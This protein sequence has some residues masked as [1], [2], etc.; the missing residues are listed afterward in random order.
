MKALSVS[1]ILLVPGFIA[2]SSEPL[3]VVDAGLNADA[4]VV[5]DAGPQQTPEERGAY[6][7]TAVLECD[8]CHTPEL[9][10]GEP[11]MSRHLAGRPEFVDLDRM[12]PNVGA[13]PAP[14]LTPHATG[15]QTWSDIQI[16][17]SLK[18]GYDKDEV[19][20][21]S[22]MPYWVYFNMS[23]RDLDA[24]V[25]YLRSIP[26]VDQAIPDR[27]PLPT[28]LNAPVAY[29]RAD[30]M[31]YSSLQFGDANFSQAQYGRYLVSFANCLNCH[32]PTAP[33]GA[34]VPINV[35][36]LLTGGKKYPASRFGLMSPPYPA[37][38]TA[39]NLTPS[40]NGLQG[41]TAEQVAAAL[42][43]GVDADGAGLC[44]P[45]T[46]GGMS[47]YARMTDEDAL[48]I[49]Y[50]LTTIPAVET[51]TATECTAQ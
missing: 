47:V 10:S 14:N 43:T 37:Q 24:I 35:T 28:P 50:Y 38:I 23:D 45:M 25:A 12:D 11:D 19:P 2:C 33:P 15:L 34:T 17:R 1:L 26:A 16:K 4:A 18:D 46:S 8:G 41:W 31:P 30:L 48:A 21:H 51:A 42:K 6:L 3:P 44:P 13:I 29:V 49:G 9:P 22:I 27:Q 20:I 7:V 32:S 39:S 40:S 36:M 5:P